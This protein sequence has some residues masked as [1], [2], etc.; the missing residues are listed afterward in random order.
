MVVN[1][2]LLLELCR[3]QCNKET[4]GVL[5]HFVIYHLRIEG[6]SVSSTKK[7]DRHDITKILLK[8]ALKTIKQNNNQTYS[9]VQHDMVV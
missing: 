5:Y 9:G 4:Y 2:I 7:T 1:I 6:I 3:L 8:V